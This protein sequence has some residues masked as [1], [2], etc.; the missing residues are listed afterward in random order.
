MA[1][2]FEMLLTDSFAKGVKARLCRRYDLATK[3]YPEAKELIQ[4]VGRLYDR[5]SEVVHQ[6]R[7]DGELDIRAAQ[8]AFTFAFIG[9]VE[10]LDRLPPEASDPIAVMLGDK[11]DK[12]S[13]L[14]RIL[15]YWR[16]HS[17]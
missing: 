5:R 8:K 3:N 4:V 11:T 9:L 13:W 15:S 14:R 10:L 2:A 1:T 17:A 6:G 12:I 16:P 7:V